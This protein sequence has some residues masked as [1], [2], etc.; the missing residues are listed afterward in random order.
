MKVLYFKAYVYWFFRVYLS[1]F[2]GLLLGD[3][4]KPLK[5]TKPGTFVSGF[6]LRAGIEPALRLREQDFK[7]C[8]S[9]SST[10]W[11]GDSYAG[12]EAGVGPRTT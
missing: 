3:G 11:A 10:I 4:V 8:V 9:T 6:V 5:R 1:I 12:E 7:S 2:D